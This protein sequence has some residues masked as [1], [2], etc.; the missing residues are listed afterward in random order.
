MSDSPKGRSKSPP[1]KEGTLKE[2][3]Q[4]SQK[5]KVRLNELETIVFQTLAEEVQDSILKEFLGVL[6]ALL[7]VFLCLIPLTLGETYYRKYNPLSPARPSILIAQLTETL[8]SYTAWLGDK[9]A[10]LLDIYSWVKDYIQDFAVVLKGMLQLVILPVIEFFNA[11][12]EYYERVYS[13]GEYPIF[14][15]FLGGVAGLS[16][17]I[18]LAWKLALGKKKYASI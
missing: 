1:L 6:K 2:L 17:S 12:V 8:T 18:L 13:S 9:L 14:L 15:F 7:G 5:T 3:F 4:R 10:W 11:Q 16:L